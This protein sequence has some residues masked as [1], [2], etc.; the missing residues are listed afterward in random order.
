MPYAEAKKPRPARTRQARITSTYDREQN[1]RA[2]LRIYG[3]EAALQKRRELESLPSSPGRQRMVAVCNEFI[4]SN[5]GDQ[6]FDGEC[7]M[8]DDDLFEKTVRLYVSQILWSFDR[9]Q[10]DVS[11]RNGEKWMNLV[12]RLHVF[13]NDHI[14]DSL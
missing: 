8:A 10:R 14:E 4:T 13:I 7:K 9:L 3:E 1:L 11:C 6:L 2:F 5:L 12:G